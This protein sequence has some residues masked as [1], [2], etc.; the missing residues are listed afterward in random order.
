MLALDLVAQAIKFKGT[1][2][3]VLINSNKNQEVLK[4]I[5]NCFDYLSLEKPIML[6][7]HLINTEK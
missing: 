6:I 7:I 3:L 5:N 1:C 4:E 2:I